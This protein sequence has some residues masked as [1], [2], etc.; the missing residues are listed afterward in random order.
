MCWSRRCAPS[1]LA[2]VGETVVVPLGM[3]V[4]ALADV[5]VGPGAM[6]CVRAVLRAPDLRTE[7][8]SVALAWIT[9]CPFRH[10]CNRS[11]QILRALRVPLTQQMLA[12]LLTRLSD[13]VASTRDDGEGPWMPCRRAHGKV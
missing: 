12:E 5:Q 10:S 1:A 9:G 6:A 4:H 11:V 2:A 8:A 13:V 3:A 7:W